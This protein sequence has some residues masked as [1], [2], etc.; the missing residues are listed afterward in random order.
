[1]S[2]AEITTCM[3][4]F[5]LSQVLQEVLVFDSVWRH[6]V[7]VNYTWLCS[8]HSIGPVFAFTLY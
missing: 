8:L 6:L 4:Y 3:L 2:E 7:H 1:M 5:Q